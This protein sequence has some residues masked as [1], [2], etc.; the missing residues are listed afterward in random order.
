MLDFLAQRGADTI[1]WS[2]WELLDAYERSLGA[3]QGRERVKV[4]PRDHMV[5][6]ALGRELP[7][8]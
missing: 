7:Q 8:D 3:P 1:E 4:V 6:V 2:G 5:A